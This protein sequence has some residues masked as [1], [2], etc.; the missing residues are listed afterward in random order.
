M[1]AFLEKG[2]ER[3]KQK[4]NKEKE[5]V[6]TNIGAVTNRQKEKYKGRKKQFKVW[7]KKDWKITWADNEEQ[8]VATSKYWY[9]KSLLCEAIVIKTGS[10]VRNV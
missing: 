9:S 8:V 4:E 1:E 5:V 10:I 6:E 7:I 3:R 2:K